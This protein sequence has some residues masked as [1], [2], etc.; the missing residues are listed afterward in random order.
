MRAYA[1]KITD[2][3]TAVFSIETRL[4]YSESGAPNRL[5]LT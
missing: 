2:S 4:S 3:D 5:V 1:V